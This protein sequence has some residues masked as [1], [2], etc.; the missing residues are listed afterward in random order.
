MQP[1]PPRNP[2]KRAFHEVSRADV[3]QAST[4]EPRLTRRQQY[5]VDMIADQLAF[6][7][8][9]DREE[10]RLHKRKR[11]LPVVR[12]RR[13]FT[14]AEHRR[15]ILLRFG[16]LDSM[17]RAH[18]TSKEVFHLTGVKPSSQHSIIKRWV[19]HGF[20]VISLKHQRGPCKMLSYND[21]VYIAN[22]RTLMEQR[23]LSLEQRAE[24]LKRELGLPKLSAMT[25]WRVYQEFGAKYVKPKIVYR[26]KN[27]RQAELCAQQ[28][29]FSCMITKLMIECPHIEIVYVDETTFHLWQA[30]SRVWLKEGMRI[31]MPDTRGHSITMIGAISTMRGLFHTHTF[32]ATN[33]TMTFLPFIIKLKEKC[34]GRRCVVVMDNLSV[35]KTLEVRKHFNEDDFQLEFLP[36][37]SC[38]LN[39]IEKAW[40]IIKAEWRRTSYMVLQNDSKTEV[41]IRAAVDFIQGIAESQDVEKMKK[42]A[43]CN[44]RTM[45]L[46]LR[47]HLV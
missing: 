19:L 2:K 22:P 20:K 40:N 27:E 45:A 7:E 9:R 10:V 33:N 26:S 35:H 41:K 38:E 29:E 1:P 28:Q 23:H 47:G 5:R 15:V 13:E 32:A 3:F 17:E 37:Q 24:K 11:L 31:E 30:P 39:P 36:P 8:N 18:H 6:L 46:T 21:R 25:V 34:Q 16:S 14:L 43:H 12:Y 44:F 42:V 4:H